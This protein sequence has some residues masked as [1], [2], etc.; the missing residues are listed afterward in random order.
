[1]QDVKANHLVEQVGGGTEPG[2]GGQRR[3]GTVETVARF[4]QQAA[5]C[6]AV[7]P[8]VRRRLE[9]VVQCVDG[10]AVRRVESISRHH[11]GGRH[12][13]PRA[14]AVAGTRLQA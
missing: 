9:V 5:R 11:V 7:V 6:L 3:H 10:V 13:A 1:V 14:R 4:K 2:H 8:R 12:V